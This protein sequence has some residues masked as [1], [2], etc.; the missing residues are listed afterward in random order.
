MFKFLHAADIHLDSALKDLD[1]YE[2]AP[3]V[4]IRCAS[5]RA[6][7]N[8]VRLALDERVAFVLI[9]G[10]LYDGD[11]PDYHTGLFF[12]AEMAKLRE[13]GIPVYLIQGNHDAANRMTRQLRLPE[14]VIFLS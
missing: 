6:L 8:L 14:R 5:R 11:W 4:E 3:A 12:A 7:E 2:G 9:A 13:A 10:D 1:R